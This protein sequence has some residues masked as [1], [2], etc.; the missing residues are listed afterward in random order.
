MAASVSRTRQVCWGLTIL[1]LSKPLRRHFKWAEGQSNNRGGLII[2]AWMN[3]CDL[4]LENVLQV[5][6]FSN[7]L[8]NRN[9]NY[10]TLRIKKKSLNTKH[11]PQIVKWQVWV[12]GY[13]LYRWRNTTWTPPWSRHAA[14]ECNGQLSLVSCKTTHLPFR[15]VQCTGSLWCSQ[16]HN[17]FPKLRCLMLRRLSS[18]LLSHLSVVLLMDRAKRAYKKTTVKQEGGSRLIPALTERLQRL[19]DGFT[20]LIGTKPWVLQVQ[21]EI[22]HKGCCESLDSLTWSQ[23]STSFQHRTYAHSAQ[24]ITDYAK[25]TTGRF[26]QL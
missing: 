5:K 25:M 26:D 20:S 11:D 17:Y 6:L 13:C 1:S 9:L 14:F 12:C 2:K 24:S 8:K 3:L 4:T 15:C 22:R 21:L 19:F 7:H 16:H 23:C 10:F 18:S